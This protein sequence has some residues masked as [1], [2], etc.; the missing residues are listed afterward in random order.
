[1]DLFSKNN[2]PEDFKNALNQI[3]NIGQLNDFLNFFILNGELKNNLPAQTYQL[4]VQTL[5]KTKSKLYDELVSPSKEKK[6]D[7]IIYRM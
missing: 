1:L 5:S 2:F 4:M 3:N 7:A 6:S